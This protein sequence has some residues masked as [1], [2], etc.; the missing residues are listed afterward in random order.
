[1]LYNQ[2]LPQ[3]KENQLVQE[4]IA[5]MRDIRINKQE[6][7]DKRMKAK[8]QQLRD[9]I[10]QEEFH[11]ILDLVKYNHFVASRKKNRTSFAL[12]YWITCF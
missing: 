5:I 10:S 7:R 9:V 4:E 12:H 3:K 11:I 8:K 1:M 6:N 2:A